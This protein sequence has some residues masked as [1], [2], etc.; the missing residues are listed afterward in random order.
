[1]NMRVFDAPGA[2]LEALDFPGDE[3]DELRENAPKRQSVLIKESSDRSAFRSMHL[4]PR[5]I[6]FAI[7][8]QRGAPT[9]S[10]DN[11]PSFKKMCSLLDSFKS[12]AKIEKFHRVGLRFFNLD[13]GGLPERDEAAV[14]QAFRRAT[15]NG[16]VESVESVI[17]ASDDLGIHITGKH[18]DGS[19]YTFK[20]GPCFKKDLESNLENIDHSG[21]LEKSNYV[22]DIDFFEQ[23]VGARIASA[24]GWTVPYVK[25]LD[26]CVKSINRIFKL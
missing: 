11:D 22:L 6:V 1:M 5:S 24:R 21:I 13:Q 12:F 4:D 20:S 17:G 10:F 25:R 14:G 18:Q 23:D 9:S 16:F 7:E 8:W 26:E 19:G 15:G 3:W 2:C